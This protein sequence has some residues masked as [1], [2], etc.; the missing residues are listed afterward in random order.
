MVVSD[1]NPIQ[2]WLTPLTAVADINNTIDLQSLG[3]TFNT[4]ARNGAVIY[5][6]YFHLI[7]NDQAF[8]IGILVDDNTHDFILSGRNQDGTLW[9]NFNFVQVS[10]DHF[11][12]DLDF[13]LY[14]E[15]INTKKFFV[16]IDDTDD[17][18]RAASDHQQFKSDIQRSV[19]INYMND[20]VPFLDILTGVQMQIR[21]PGTFVFE[22][23]PE[24]VETD[25]LSD[26][27]VVELTSEVK[28]TRL[29]QTE[30]MPDYM[31]RKLKYILKCKTKQID[32]EVGGEYW[33]QETPYEKD[34]AP[35]PTDDKSVFEFRR[36]RVTLTLD[37]SI[38]R[39]VYTT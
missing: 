15:I 31:H 8:P 12:V 28:R 10:G 7:Q 29:L 27:S 38:K 19:L 6:P 3:V 35:G 24:T 39:N 16:V 25:S 33:K 13:S 14:P 22:E 5:R 9:Q 20:D 32:G 2:F 1:L 4:R 18:I 30:Y 34:G 37:G 26:G 21:I 23:E 11:R 36:G 17:K